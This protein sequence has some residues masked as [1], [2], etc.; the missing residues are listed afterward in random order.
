MTASGS[1][2]KG[3]CARSGREALPWSLAISIRWNEAKQL[4]LV[5]P[6]DEPH[7]EGHGQR[8]LH[9]DTNGMRAALERWRPDEVVSLPHQQ[10]AI[11]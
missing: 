6:D 1:D 11:D 7:V 2:S 4:L 9:G 5:R 10:K 3:L 8:K